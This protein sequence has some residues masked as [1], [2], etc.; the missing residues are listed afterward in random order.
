[1]SE[2]YAA[3]LDPESRSEYLK[4]A[5]AFFEDQAGQ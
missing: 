1:L 3:W 4:A 5:K 2:A